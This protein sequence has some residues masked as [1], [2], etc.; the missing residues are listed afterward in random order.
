MI[1]TEVLDEALLDINLGGEK[2]YPA[3]GALIARGLPFVFSTGFNRDGVPHGYEAPP[4]L[5]KPSSIPELGDMPTMLLTTK[6][7]IP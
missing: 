7:R 4:R 6:P 5:Q 2:S 3:A 1:E